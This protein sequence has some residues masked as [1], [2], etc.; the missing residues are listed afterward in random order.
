MQD[1]SSFSISD[2]IRSKKSG[3]YIV[4]VQFNIGGGGRGGSYSPIKVTG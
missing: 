2:P 4:M 3:H 1:K